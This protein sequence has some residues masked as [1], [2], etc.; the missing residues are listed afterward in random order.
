MLFDTNY[1]EPITVQRSISEIP[2]IPNLYLPMR[3][4]DSEEMISGNAA[5]LHRI[6]LMGGLPQFLAEF[7]KTTY[8]K[9]YQDGLQQ[10]KFTGLT[11]LAECF[12]RLEF[13]D[14]HS[15]IY[16]Q[17]IVIHQFDYTTAISPMTPIIDQYSSLY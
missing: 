9:G 2:L 7:Y 1:L 4:E 11:Y 3:N 8:L 5:L 12:W 14:P 6:K 17:Q 10:L 15:M 16:Y 13:Y